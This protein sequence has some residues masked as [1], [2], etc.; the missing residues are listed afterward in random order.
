[1]SKPV[2]SSNGQASAN[3]AV[4]Q[5]VSEKIRYVMK[6][7]GGVKVRHRAGGR[8]DPSR[9]RSARRAFRGNRNK[10]LRALARGRKKNRGKLK[11]IRKAMGRALG[12]RESADVVQGTIQSD[13]SMTRESVLECLEAI[14]AGVSV[15]SVID[16]IQHGS[17][18]VEDRETFADLGIC[19][20]E[21]L[22]LAE[23]TDH[24][25]VEGN[26]LVIE[27]RGKLSD[28]EKDLIEGL[29]SEASVE[30]VSDQKVKLTVP[31]LAFTEEGA[32]VDPYNA[33]TGPPKSYGNEDDTL[34]DNTDDDDSDAT[35]LPDDP[36]DDSATGMQGPMSGTTS[37]TSV[38][39]LP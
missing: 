22:D 26:S 36:E 5:P 13:T 12:Q 27:F 15:G 3:S 33:E 21:E 8:A 14:R 30:W 10:I 35:D 2:S 11:R 38:S 34:P 29:I 39:E 16:I 24:V 17:P 18:V 7:V 4:V 1:M 37:T 32:V 28:T 31:G 9:S 23:G 19:L 25:D 6:S 20:L